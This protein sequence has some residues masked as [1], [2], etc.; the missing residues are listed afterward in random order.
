MAADGVQA[1]VMEASS[2]GI[3]LQRIAGIRFG[4]AVFTNFSQD[5]LDFHGNMEEYFRAKQKLFEGLDGQATAVI[6]GDDAR[7]REVARATAAAIL[8]YGIDSRSDIRAEKIEGGLGGSTFRLSTPTGSAVIG[9]NLAGR[10]NVYNA[11]AAAG[12]ALAM[13]IPLEQVRLG[14]ESVASVAGR[15]ELV[16][17]GQDFSVV[18][19]YAHTPEEIDRLLSALRPLA[20]RRIITV[21]GCGGDRDRTKRPLMGQA[22]A[23]HSDLL[24]V[25]SDNPR[26]EDP[27]AIIEHILPGVQGSAH[28]VI[29]DRRAAIH[30]AL[31]LA[32]ADDIVVIAGKGHE[33]Y[34]II[35]SVRTHFDDREVAREAL[36]TLGKA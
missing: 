6:N 22:A 7:G 25:T 2:H 34:Q 26:T 9:L 17:A 15:F 23:R 32:R 4:T 10:H 28:E 14:L 19:D 36:Q 3:Q 1:V 24:I 29:P 12:A 35:G 8:T 33:D 13:R 11:M 5:H 30:R 31:S 18:V 20:Q 21:F 27:A 16:S